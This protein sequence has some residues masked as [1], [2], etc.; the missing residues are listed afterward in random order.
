MESWASLSP[1][2][3]ARVSRG[4]SL[5][6]VALETGIPEGRLSAAERHLAR[7]THAERRLLA[8]YFDTHEA[9]LFDEV[10]Q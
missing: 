4:I 9:A 1:L 8:R 5:L 10:V 6:R 7:L 3:R 2:R